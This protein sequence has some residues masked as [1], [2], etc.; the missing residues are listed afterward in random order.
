MSTSRKAN[1][2]SSMPRKNKPSESLNLFG[3]PSPTKAPIGSEEGIAPDEWKALFDAAV[4]FQQLKCWEWMSDDELFGVQHP[5]T[6]EVGYCCVM[7]EL[8]E[9]RAL[10]VYPGSEG[11]ASYRILR[12]MANRGKLDHVR[13]R[14]A[15]LS[16]QLCLMASFEDRSALHEQDLRVIRDLGLKFR[17]KNVWPMFRS[18][19]PGYVPWFLTAAEVRLLTVALQQA[20]QVAKQTRV[21]PEM[22]GSVEEA[23][24]HM[25]IRKREGGVWQDV[26]EP[27]PAHEPPAV[28]PHINEL[29]LTQLKKAN[30]PFRGTWETD[31]V[32]LPSS[33]SEGPRPYFPTML[34]VLN[35]EGMALGMEMFKP[36][37]VEASVPQA[38]L[39][40]LENVKARPQSLLVGSEQA[41]T[42]LKPIA[43]KLQI[44]IHRVESMP[45]L[46]HFLEGLEGFLMGEAGPMP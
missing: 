16:S 36:G 9:V 41:L 42:L 15:L 30:Y 12:E 13:G 22:L 14:Y 19:R 29:Q 11:L 18:Y 45:A 26:R 44:R 20:V 7:G 28:V 5:A 33:I 43:Q 2:S 1:P 37:E 6:G 46:E 39:A 4:A 40:L 25:L 17:G 8:G 3:S 24:W 23:D 35:S 27:A 21:N 10:N 38:F 32:V 34:P 31:C